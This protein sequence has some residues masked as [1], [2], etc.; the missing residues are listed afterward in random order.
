MVSFYYNSPTK[1]V[2]GSGMLSVLHEQELPEKKALVLERK[3]E[4]RG[5]LERSYR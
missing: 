1:I 5:I 3:A 2:F 4:C